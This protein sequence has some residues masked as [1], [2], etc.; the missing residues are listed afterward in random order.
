MMMSSRS[1]LAPLIFVLLAACGVHAPAAKGSYLQTPDGVRIYT[2]S[3]QC[4]SPLMIDTLATHA[5]YQGLTIVDGDDVR[6]NP[7]FEFNRTHTDANRAG[8]AQLAISSLQQRIMDACSNWYR[9]AD[10]D[11][12]IYWS[13]RDELLID[14][15]HLAT[16]IEA[17]KSVAEYEALLDEA[18][19]IANKRFQDDLRRGH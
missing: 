17:A 16:R 8:R 18:S 19:K 12:A 6:R 5:D 11:K 1:K 13:Q 10:A 15:V 4:V 7:R 3:G 14:V 2:D 9:A